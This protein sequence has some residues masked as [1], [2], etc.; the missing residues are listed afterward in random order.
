MIAAVVNG[1]KHVTPHLHCSQLHENGESSLDRMTQSNLATLHQALVGVVNSKEGTAYGFR[2]FTS[3]GK[4]GFGGKTGTTQVS[5]ISMQDRA[6][7]RVNNR[8]EFLRDHAL[9]VGFAPADNPQHVIAVILENGGWGAN[10]CRIGQKILK[11][12]M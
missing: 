7:N 12:L 4:D 1:G 10:A 9:F 8:A 11:R 3:D 5:G 6:A 2:F